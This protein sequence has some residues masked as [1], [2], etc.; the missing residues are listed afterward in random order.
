VLPKFLYIELLRQEL[1]PDPEAP[2]NI[3]LIVPSGKCAVFDEKEFDE[4]IQKTRNRLRMLKK[5]R[6]EAETHSTMIDEAYLKSL[7]IP[8]KVEELV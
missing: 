1:R 5:L 3:W 4:L 7:E 8:F 6:K 2:R